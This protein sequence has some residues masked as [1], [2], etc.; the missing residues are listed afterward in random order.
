M[1]PGSSAIERDC[2]GGISPSTIL[3]LKANHVLQ[4]I[5]ALT[6]KP[7]AKPDS[8]LWKS[9]PASW[10]AVEP[11]SFVRDTASITDDNRSKVLRTPHT[12]RSNLGGTSGLFSRMT[13]TLMA[14]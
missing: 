13:A 1:S 8:I 5:H 12:E 10:T 2:S 6:M 11:P 14:R 4:T 3:A 9:R 7:N